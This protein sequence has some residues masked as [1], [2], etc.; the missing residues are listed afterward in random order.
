MRRRDAFLLPL[1][2]ISVS[3]AT[4][5]PA[6]ER[7]RVLMLSLDGADPAT[8]H[9]LHREGK[10][11]AGGFERFFRQGQVAE[12]LVPVNPTITA[13]NHISLVTGY[14]AGM[15]GIVG[16]SVRLPGMPLS[17]KVS[18]FA[19]EI[20][21][22][23]L[24]EAARRQGLSVATSAWPGS[25]LPLLGDARQAVWRPLVARAP[26]SNSMKTR[27]FLVISSSFVCLLLRGRRTFG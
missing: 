8:L 11:K 23:T 14:P 15:T 18:G 17:Q 19:A 21:T 22:E 16:N 26:T 24:W 2:L 1:L 4:S 5:D 13:P 12:A 25:E 20:H 7:R 6:A 9:R 3:C 10:L 27:V